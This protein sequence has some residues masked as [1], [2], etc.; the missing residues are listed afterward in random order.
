MTTT[1]PNVVIYSKPGCCLC[2]KAKAILLKVQEKIPFTLQ[3]IDI[4]QN[5]A[6]FEK[7]Q[8]VIPVVAINGQDLFVSKISEFRF[9]K[10]LLEII[11]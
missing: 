2:D 4:S 5:Q 7:Y 8:Y 6:L 10:T 9:R 1:K 11:D 3:V